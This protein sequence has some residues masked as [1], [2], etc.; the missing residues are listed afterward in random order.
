[1]IN[2]LWKNPF[3]VEFSL[4]QVGKH[5]F[6]VNVFEKNRIIN[7][8]TFIVEY[9]SCMCTLNCCVCD[10][11]AEK[12]ILF[13]SLAPLSFAFQLG[14]QID[15][16]LYW[17][18][19]SI[20]SQQFSISTHRVYVNVINV[21]CY[22]SVSQQI[23][24]PF[25]SSLKTVCTV[26]VQATIW[27]YISIFAFVSDSYRVAVAIMIVCSEFSTNLFDEPLSDLDVCV[28]FS[29]CHVLDFL[30]RNQDMGLHSFPVYE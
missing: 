5:C 8:H 11:H 27:Q 7:V 23:K 16:P 10:S 21:N 25:F 28:H 6:L 29:I 2:E 20:D 26:H 18:W 9:V 24:W 15:L 3:H 19:K 4:C 1:M 30:I 22:P 13:K 17:F 14:K 12:N